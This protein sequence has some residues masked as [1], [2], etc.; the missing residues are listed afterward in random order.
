MLDKL[1]KAL[2]RQD[3]YG[4]S[5]GV[6]YKGSGTYQTRLGGVCTI[7]T[8]VLIFINFL[9]LITGL[10]DHSLQEESTSKTTYENYE[11]ER[12]TFSENDFELMLVG[13]RVFP[14]NIG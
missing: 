10:I 9:N 13:N 1:S 3:L 14:S 5:I 2:I 8:Y 6:H 4:H 12:Y 7:A 11:T